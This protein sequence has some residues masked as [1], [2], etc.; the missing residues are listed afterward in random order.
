MQVNDVWQ[1][2]RKSTAIEESPLISSNFFSADEC[3]AH[4]RKRSSDA[5]ITLL[6]AVASGGDSCVCIS[7]V[8]TFVALHTAPQNLS[9]ERSL[10]TFEQQCVSK[11]VFRSRLS[12]PTAQFA[13]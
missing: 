5:I 2:L 10:K 13:I 8:G 9:S 4:F 6:L 3:G 1:F 12:D 7:D 11:E